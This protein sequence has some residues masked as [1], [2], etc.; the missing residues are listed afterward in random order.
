[1]KVQILYT[2]NTPGDRD[3]AYLQRRLSEFRLANELVEADSRE[4]IALGELYDLMA[5]PSV[6]VTDDSGGLIKDWQGTLP[7]A[8]EVSGAYGAV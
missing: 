3:V 7:S 8:E 4:G 5:R 1:M 6:V 2:P